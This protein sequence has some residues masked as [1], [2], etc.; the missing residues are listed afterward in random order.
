MSRSARY[1]FE[2]IALALT[3]AFLFVLFFEL[4]D[5]VF[6]N[7]AYSDGISWVFLPAGF[8]IILV[9]VLGLPGAVGLVLGS[10][11]IDS[12]LFSADTWLLPFL[13]GL[14]SGLTPWLVMKY[15]QHKG[16]LAPHI[17]SMTAQ[18]LLQM[19]LLFS[20]ASAISHQLLWWWL[21]RQDVNIWIDV[22]P[23]FIGN[24]LGALLMLYGFKF[25][26]DRIRPNR[27]SP[28]D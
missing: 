12:A 16:W 14:V 20:A 23:M 26:L 4:N 24:A 2:Q 19:T 25:A 9:L 10:W 17:M 7:F 11:F 18:R 28:T 8:R 15:L 6:A 21:E 27:S 1:L 22:W 3:S 5:W 13:N